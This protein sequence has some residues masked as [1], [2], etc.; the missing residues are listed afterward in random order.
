MKEKRGEQ[1][2]IKRLMNK[3]AIDAPPLKAVGPYSL[4]VQAGG[5]VYLSGQV[6]LDPA[7]GKLVSGDIGQQTR[8]CLENL[9]TVL[10]AANLGFEH[11]VKTTVF[12]TDMRDFTDMNNVYK[13]YMSEPFPARSTIQVAALPLGARVEIEAI[14]VLP[15]DDWPTRL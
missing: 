4:A 6:H 9:K 1:R 5:V 10:A 15:A 12:L 2:G 3:K 8:Q 7:T 11:V 13:T 14:A